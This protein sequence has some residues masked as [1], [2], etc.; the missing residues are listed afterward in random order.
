MDVPGVKNESSIKAY[1][2]IYYNFLH[3]PKQIAISQYK[4]FWT[5]TMHSA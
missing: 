2:N 3:R 5:L 4:T 1:V